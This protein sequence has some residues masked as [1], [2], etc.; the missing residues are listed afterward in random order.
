MV[1]ARSL[2]LE[3]CAVIPIQA[4][5]LRLL[6]VVSASNGVASMRLHVYCAFYLNAPPANVRC[7][8][9]WMP[10]AACDNGPK[11]D[12]VGELSASVRKAGLRMGL[13]HSIFEWFH[14]LY[15]ADKANAY[16][17]SRY[18]DEVYLPQAKEINTLCLLYSTFS[19]ALESCTVSHFVEQVQARLDLVRWRLGS[20]LVVLEVA[21]TACMAV[22]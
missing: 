16:A 15:L 12:L 19:F 5:F 2:W 10:G 9:A 22:Q 14:P 11:R 1:L 8:A 13:Y 18:V 6:R 17:T 21:R 20:Q 7:L 4:V 3:R